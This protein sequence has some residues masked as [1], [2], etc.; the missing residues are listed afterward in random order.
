MRPTNTPTIDTRPWACPSLDHRTGLLCN[1]PDQFSLLTDSDF[2]MQWMEGTAKSFGKKDNGQG[3]LYI[4]PVCQNLEALVLSRRIRKDGSYMVSGDYCLAGLEDIESI[5]YNI[6]DDPLV[7]A[8]KKAA[9]SYR[10]KTKRLLILE[11]EAPFSILSAL[12]NPIDLFLCFEE[13]PVLLLNVLRK[14]AH[15]SALYLRSC[16]DAG[17]DFIS[18]ADPTGSLDLV[19]PDYYKRFCGQAAL[20]LMKECRPFL[21]SS[22]IHLC[23]KMSRS[24]L[25]TGL[26]R[27]DR[28]RC[29]V[30]EDRSGNLWEVLISA[31]RDPHVSF[32]GGVCLHGDFCGE[33]ETYIL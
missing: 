15:A 21:P 26:I 18:L 11:A 5:E 29:F 9:A 31:A 13:K 1:N 27:I 23:P 33:M 3:K 2:V 4:L 30:S 10:D 24:M 7:S 22:L 6:L 12:M 20:Y 17:F 32:T 19:G 8:M 25:M 28:K 16:L 14:I